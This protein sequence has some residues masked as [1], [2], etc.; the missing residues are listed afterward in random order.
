MRHLH[1]LALLC[2]AVVVH[3][4]T[5]A[6]IISGGRSKMFNHERYWN[7]CAFLY[8]TLRHDYHIS[9]EQICL[10]MADGD[11]PANDMLC[12][13][14][15]GFASSPTDLDGDGQPDVTLAATR[16]NVSDA[17]RRL[18]VRLASSDHLFIF[19]TDHGERDADG[20]VHL[21]LWDNEQLM[22]DELAAM[23]NQCHPATMSILLGQC[24]AGAFVASLQ[25]EGRIITAA[26]A[27]DQMSWSCKDRPYDEFVYHW[28]CA[29]AQHDEQGQ[30]V[31]SDSDGD[32]RI[33]MAEAFHYA[34]QHDRRPETPCFT[35]LPA[36]LT[37]RWSFS[38]VQDMVGIAP[39]NRETTTNNR[40]YDLQGRRIK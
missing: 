14:A 21:W 13:G 22:P 6:V 7:D 37:A 26:C 5:Y 30:P 23:V 17:F 2:C 35:A 3:A 1:L 28:T 27:A 24:Y 38:G 16:Q 39:Y 9:K 15:T 40:Y 19:I 18:S 29:V 8:R 12:Y 10:L 34:C 36:V 32:G 25:A 4:E 20:S 11:N 31:H 33:S